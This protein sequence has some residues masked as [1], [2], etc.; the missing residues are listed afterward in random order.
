MVNDLGFKISKDNLKIKV[1]RN[2]EII[3]L[4]VKKKKN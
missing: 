3:T 1:H 2:S 4:L